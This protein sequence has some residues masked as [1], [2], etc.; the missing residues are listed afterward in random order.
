MS[1]A[2]WS[3]K[4]LFTAYV[5]WLFSSV[6]Y[7]LAILALYSRVFTTPAFR[8]WSYAFS[9]VTVAYCVGYFA[10]FVTSCIPVDHL[11]NPRPG[12]HCRDGRISDFSTLT[13][14]IILDLGIIILPLPTLWGLQLPTKKKII[15]TVMLSFGFL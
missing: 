6:F 5:C 1:C 9:A 2:D 11:W 7:K 8:W 12:G 13:I 3:R 4:F 10:V 14:N 15:V